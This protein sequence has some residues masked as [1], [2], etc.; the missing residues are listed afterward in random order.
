MIPPTPTV[1][2]CVLQR[3]IG[4]VTPAHETVDSRKLARASYVPE[5]DAC[6][7]SIHVYNLPMLM[8][9]PPRSRILAH[10][11]ADDLRRL[12]EEVV[13]AAGSPLRQEEIAAR[14]G[15]SRIPVREAF[16]LLEA[17][18]LATVHA[19]RGAFVAQP[20]RDAVAELFD[21]RLMLEADLLRRACP[22]ISVTAYDQ[23]ATIDAQLAVT[24]IPLQWVR[25]D[26]QFHF[27][28]Y[29]AA[30]RPQTLALT[31]TLRRSLNSYY[32]R[33]LEPGTRASAWRAEHRALLRCL[34]RRDAAKAIRI[35]HDHLRGTERVL[36]AALGRSAPAIAAAAS[37]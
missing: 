2:R 31:R 8:A 30:D 29:E 23:I 28:M 14:L 18:G 4:Q 21:V 15:V 19:N 5:W 16:R 3:R 27:A 24:R 17:D 33:Y 10:D 25:L 32:L 36:V 7:D 20:G 1:A 13:Y 6:G 11:I 9:T 37:E 35:L 12:I 26:E 34:R 22:R